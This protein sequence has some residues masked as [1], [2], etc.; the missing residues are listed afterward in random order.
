MDNSRFFIDKTVK[1][2]ISTLVGNEDPEKPLSDQEIM[3]KLQ[4]KGINIARRTIAKYRLML[5]IPPSHLR[6][7]Y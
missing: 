5:H 7:S 4:E 6:K 2:I 3:E 1:D